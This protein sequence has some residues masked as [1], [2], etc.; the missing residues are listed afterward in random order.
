MIQDGQRARRFAALAL[1]A[2]LGAV[3]VGYRLG[4]HPLWDPD[5]AKH[6][7]VAREMLVEGRW[8]EPLVNFEPYHHKPSAL[9]LAIGAAYRVFG[10]NEFGARFVS[11]TCA[12][13]T[14][15]LV[16]AFGLRRSVDE[17]LLAT[18]LLAAC[19][20]FLMVG[21]FTNFDAPLTLCMTS[22]VLA[23]ARLIESRRA[24]DAL[25]LFVSVGFAFLVK[26]PAA[27]A[28]I[29]IPVALALWHGDLEWRDLELSRGLMALGA[30]TGSWII[31]TL[32]FAPRYLEEFLWVH[33]VERYLAP[34]GADVF[35]P[36]P[37]WFF[38]PVVA[39]ALLPWSVWVP[40]ALT[41]VVVGPSDPSS[42]VLAEYALWVVVFFSLSS[43]KLATYVLPAVPALA[44]LTARWLLAERDEARAGRVASMLSAILCVLLCPAA[45]VYLRLEA[46]PLVRY[47]IVFLP[48]SLA[49]IAVAMSARR[50]ALRAAVSLSAALAASLLAFNVFAAAPLSSWVSDADL[51]ARA[52]AFGRPRCVIAYR[53]R[54]FS[55]LFYTGWPMQYHVPL[56]DVRAA[57]YEPGGA[58]LLTEDQSIFH[59][60]EAAPG[61]EFIELARNPRHV[62]YAVRSPWG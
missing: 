20:L 42:R 36:Q 23:L 28:L 15:V 9:Y 3:L 58:L 16:C 1:T 10:T 24:R 32:V 26:G 8:L 25:W 53:V 12:W 44:L 30:I 40:A 59:L 34:V 54:P 21:R 57:L 29:A 5:E 31:P 49:G 22:A 17:G 61:V 60:E 11:A 50:S 35:H 56:D 51:A 45:Y 48:V 47:A 46:A 2:V 33:N 13:L 41:R 19:V 27:L 62:L 7:E 38:L 18:L 43:G 52:R 6:A 39:G 4:E 55:F 14:L 37:F